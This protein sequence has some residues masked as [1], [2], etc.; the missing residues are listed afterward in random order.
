MTRTAFPMSLALAVALA[1]PA[2][3][4]QPETEVDRRLS[5]EFA[6]CIEREP[7][8]AGMR[9]CTSAEYVRQDRALNETYQRALGQLNAR[10]AARLRTAQRAWVA[11]RDA[12]C[13]SLADQDWGTLSLLSA[14]SCTVTMTVERL[15]DLEDY[16]PG[17]G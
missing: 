13:A 3:A 14:S 6:A 7:S 1:A 17:G 5:A 16:P 4:R 15:I 8:T 11:Y 12:R 2:A 10:Q 9:A